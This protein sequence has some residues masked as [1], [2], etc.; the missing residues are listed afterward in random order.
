MKNKKL[1]EIINMNLQP[2]T[3]LHIRLNSSKVARA[4]SSAIIVT[5]EGPSTIKARGIDKFPSP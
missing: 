4:R 1:S 2:T 5:S 3:A